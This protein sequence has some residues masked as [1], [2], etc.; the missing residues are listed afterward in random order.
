MR[1]SK[2]FALQQILYFGIRE[3]HSLIEEGKH[4]ESYQFRHARET[5]IRQLMNG[6]VKGFMD[7]LN[8]MVDSHVG[9][10]GYLEYDVDLYVFDEDTRKMVVRFNNF[11]KEAQATPK[12]KFNY[13]KITEKNGIYL[14]PMAQ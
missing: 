13:K 11:L 2:E 1:I 12:N 9:D 14:M 4:H 6:G 3:E 8:K 7:A 5:M 10:N